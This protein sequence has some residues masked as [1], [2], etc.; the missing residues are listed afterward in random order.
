M[1]IVSL[2]SDNVSFNSFSWNLSNSPLTWCVYW[3]NIIL[4]LTVSFWI[5]SDQNWQDEENYQNKSL[6][7]NKTSDPGHWKGP[8]SN[9][10][11]LQQDSSVSCLESDSGLK[12]HLTEEAGAETRSPSCCEVVISDSSWMSQSP[13]N[14]SLLPSRHPPQSP[15]LLPLVASSPSVSPSCRPLPSPPDNNN[16][17]GDNSSSVFFSTVQKQWW[18]TLC[19]AP[20]H[21]TNTQ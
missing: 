3:T 17:T 20:E 16:N 21:S 19:T 9:D 11:I 12:L 6:V 1:S 4:S 13:R 15:R 18:P 10:H 7:L 14:P 8:W 5:Q 2:S